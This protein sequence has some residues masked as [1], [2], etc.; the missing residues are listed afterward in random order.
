MPALPQLRHHRVHLLAAR[1]WRE[2]GRPVPADLVDEEHWAGVVTLTTP[3]LLE[4]VRAACDGPLLLVKGPEAARHYPDAALRPW[5]DVDLI[6]PE[7]EDVQQ[8]LL[9]S[10]FEPVGEPELY[11]DIH[12]LRPLRIPELP[13]V[14]EIHS[15]PKWPSRLE[16]PSAEELIARATPSPLRVQGLLG[17]PPAEHAVLLAAHAWSHGALRRLSDLVDVAAV[18]TAADPT[19]LEQTAQRWELDKIW[20]TTIAAADAI[21]DARADPWSLRLWARHLRAV[22]ERTVFESHLARWL[23]GFWGLPAGPALAASWEAVAAD[24]RPEHGEP[25]RRKLLRSGRSLRNARAPRSEHD[26]TLE[27]DEL[28]APTYLE[29]IRSEGGRK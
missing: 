13:L 20:R 5:T 15:E 8:A 27:R 26:E 12:H 10:G 18:A 14:V 4:R 16:A 17:L 2:I 11:R 3:L 7:A 1:R 24:F 23:E 29:H 22:R 6:T 25:W 28:A 9:E 19:E 21:L